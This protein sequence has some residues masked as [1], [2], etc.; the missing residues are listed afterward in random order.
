MTRHSSGLKSNLKFWF[1]MLVAMV[2]AAAA[3]F[4]S[5]SHIRPPDAVK[6]SFAERSAI[7]PIQEIS[8]LAYGQPSDSSL[9]VAIAGVL[10]PR[11]T[12]ESYQELLDYLGKKTGRQVTLFLKPT[13]AEVN[14]LLKGQRVDIAFIC[15]LAY[16]KG[17]QDFGLEL[18]VVPQM[19]G[20]TVYYSYLLVHRGSMTTSL[21]ELKASS[22]AFTDPLSN[23]GYLVPTYQLYLLNEIP[24][25]FFSRYIFTYSHDNS[26]KAVSEK[27]V[28]AAAVDSLV[29]DHMATSNP[30]I[31][32]RTRVIARW[33]P[34]GIPP[35]VVSPALDP[36]LKLQLQD[37][38]LDIHSSDEGRKILVKSGIDKF[39]LANDSI[40]NSVKEMQ[41]KLGW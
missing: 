4:L 31:I 32:S 38:F 36:Q 37:I 23:S 17:R 1:I 7:P 25:S 2:A 5:A 34:Y 8:S 19:R 27:L 30:E 26:I 22:F 13:Y 3:L 16:V 40:Y 10:S 28:D 14:E 12:L 20:D 9:R 24:G 18:L 35:V 6:V 33:G 39:V 29:Y 41:I 11:S 21:K 15:S